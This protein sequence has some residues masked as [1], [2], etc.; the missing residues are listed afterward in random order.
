MFKITI[1]DDQGNVNYYYRND[2]DVDVF[3]EDF[4]MNSDNPDIYTIIA[5][6]YVEFGGGVLRKLGEDLKKGDPV[7]FYNWYHEE[8]VRKGR[9][10]LDNLHNDFNCRLM[11]TAVFCQDRIALLYV[12]QDNALYLRIGDR[13]KGYIGWGEPISI[14]KEY[15]P[16]NIFVCPMHEEDPLFLI[17]CQSEGGIGTAYFVEGDKVSEPSRFSDGTATDI[18][19]LRM[20]M[21]EGEGLFFV[22]SYQDGDGI[23]YTKLGS[24]PFEGNPFVWYDTWQHSAADCYENRLCQVAPEGNLFGIFYRCGFRGYVR[25]ADVS[26]ELKFVHQSKE[27]VCADTLCKDMQVVRVTED[28][29]VLI[30]LAY[31]DVLDSG[32]GVMCVGS[33]LDPANPVFNPMHKVFFNTCGT[34]SITLSHP[35]WNMP[36][37]Y[38]GLSW[39]DGGDIGQVYFDLCSVYSMMPQ[40]LAGRR[41]ADYFP[42]LQ[43]SHQ[44]FAYDGNWDMFLIFT[45]DEGYG[46]FSTHNIA[47]VDIAEILPI[48]GVMAEDGLEG[49]T[50]RVNF[51]GEVIDFECNDGTPYYLDRDLKVCPKSPFPFGVGLSQTKLLLT[52]NPER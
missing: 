37:G 40:S 49:E 46:A 32:R 24:C 18:T 16:S 48:V 13:R 39:I 21:I 25:T 41:V 8:C 47:A 44:S 35:Q 3:I 38:F 31:R 10:A 50:K 26:E 33:F 27:V 43:V 5:E 14:Q 20:P 1:E 36:D 15:V 17:L 34:Q 30:V 4:L 45:T 12:G 2:D 23:G 22:V 19:A 51:F 11:H 7:E 9:T 52:K 28:D 29:N 42:G 6:E